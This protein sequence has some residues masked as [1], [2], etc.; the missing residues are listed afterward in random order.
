MT[1]TQARPVQQRHKITLSDLVILGGGPVSQALQAV[2]AAHVER[3]DRLIVIDKKPV[4]VHPKLKAHGA[5]FRCLELTAD[6]VGRV[7]EESVRKGGTVVDL[8]VD[9]STIQMLRIA[10][11]LGAHYISADLEDWP[12][13]H[14][15]SASLADR[16][17]YAWRME[18][19]RAAVGWWGNGPTAVVNMGANPG[20][21]SLCLKLALEDLAVYVLENKHLLPHG[22]TPVRQRAIEESLRS[23]DYA[24]LAEALHIYLVQVSEIDDSVSAKRPK[25]VG[26]AVGTWSPHAC[27]AE[28]LE[29]PAEAGWGTHEPEDLP[30]GA[31]RH[32]DGPGHAIYFDR[33]GAWVTVRSWAPYKKSIHGSLVSHDETTWSIPRYLEVRDGDATHR[34]RS[35][36]TVC[37][38]YGL[39]PDARTS[40]DE[41]AMNGFIMQPQS[42]VLTGDEI[43]PDRRDILGI[44]IC[45]N[46]L[47]C[48]WTGS[49][50]SAADAQEVLPGHNPTV[51]QVVGPIAGTIDWIQRNPGKGLCNAEHVDHRHVLDFATP[52]LGKPFPYS[53]L[54]DWDPRRDVA[55][56]PF[57]GWRQP[58]TED[59]RWKFAKTI[60]V[61]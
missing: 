7:L 41:A 50:M 11:S 8:T 53:V 37:Y 33:P 32:P 44:L 60:L 22:L 52:Y 14:T 47:G 13:G 18:L 59:D 54:T 28:A 12:G 36:P 45:G 21:V 26:E 27:F 39:P 25:Q 46:E 23:G 49:V 56:G 58:L 51:A 10:R 19:E 61:H 24:H 16:T 2:L 35:R 31:H 20:L 57:P 43:P 29:T 40:L 3:F 1:T 48:Q 34:V 9:T 6:N 30:P 42:R 15:G 17:Q 55:A 4:N 5:K 38:C